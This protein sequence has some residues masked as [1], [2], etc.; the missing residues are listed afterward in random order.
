MGRSKRSCEQRELSRSGWE[1]E[2]AS[3]LNIK[4]R[5]ENVR[6]R[7]GFQFKICQLR[8]QVFLHAALRM[9]RMR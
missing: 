9:R 5:K 8:Y 2:S 3:G 4:R 6:G 1:S 7:V